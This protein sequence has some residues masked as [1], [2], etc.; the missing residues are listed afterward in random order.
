MKINHNF[1]LKPGNNTE[2]NQTGNA[3]KNKVKSTKLF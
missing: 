1:F 3:F 2:I